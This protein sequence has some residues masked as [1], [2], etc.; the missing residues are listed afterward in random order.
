MLLLPAA[1]AGASSSALT[2]YLGA[3]GHWVTTGPVTSGYSIE[4]TLG[5]LLESSVAGTAPLYGCLDGSDHFLSLSPVC[6]GQTV[7]RTEGW[8]YA[9]PPSSVASSAIYRCRDGFD[10]FAATD[11]GCEGQVNEGLLGYALSSAP[12]NRYNGG[13]H[14]VTTG[15]PP[16]GDALEG[17]LG[18][19]V[20]GLSGGA[21]KPL[22]GC[23]SDGSQFLSLSLGCEGTT[24]LDV[25]GWIYS[26]APSGLGSNPIYRCRDGAD[27]FAA[28]DP[29]CEGQVTEGLLGYA[30]QSPLAPLS[31]P[32]PPPPAWPGPVATVVPLPVASHHRRVLRVKLVLSWTWHR[33]TTRLTRA[34]IGRLPRG[35]T[36]RISCRG[37][38]PAC[39]SRTMVAGVRRVRRLAGSLD[40]RVYSAGDR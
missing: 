3:P 40:G 16:S 38:G 35:A 33:A 36:I 31:A 15:I 25:E 28:T 13:S 34:R 19:L 37:P 1:A 14:W 20:Q 5:F 8:I 12:L 7:L 26:S 4:G 32:V 24:T 11:P 17:T 21:T 10:H 39:R 2:R 6:E 27:H 30:L 29:G 22:Y 18:Y 9:S 23:E